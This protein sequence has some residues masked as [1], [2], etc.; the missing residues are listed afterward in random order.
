MA[1]TP[2]T[3]ATTVDQYAPPVK[4]MSIIVLAHV[5][6]WI[7]VSLHTITAMAPLATI[8]T[9]QVPSA[10]ASVNLGVQHIPFLIDNPFV[11]MR[12]HGID[13]AYLGGERH[14]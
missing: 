7:P 6:S 3:V 5:W 2:K 12:L 9:S 13:D 14:S 8:L 1:A 11:G 4:T 10:M